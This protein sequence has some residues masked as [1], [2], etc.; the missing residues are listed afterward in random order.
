MF[1]GSSTAIHIH[2]WKRIAAFF[3]SLNSLYSNKEKNRRRKREAQTKVFS[4]PYR[5]IWLEQI[6]IDR[7]SIAIVAFVFQRFFRRRRRC[8]RMEVFFSLFLL[9]TAEWQLCPCFTISIRQSH[10]F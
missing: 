6:A 9:S 7:S 4:R 1:Y 3:F 5:H 10:T 2:Q 8:H